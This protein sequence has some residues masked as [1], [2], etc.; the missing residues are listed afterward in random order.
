MTQRIPTSKGLLYYQKIMQGKPREPL[1]EHATKMPLSLRAP[2]LFDTKFNWVM[3]F[4]GIF[5][6]LAA[7]LNVLG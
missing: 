4:I 6:F 1:Y 7:L 2:V 5:F 3:I